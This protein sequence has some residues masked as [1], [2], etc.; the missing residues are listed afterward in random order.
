M[1]I[2]SR[3]SLLPCFSFSFDVFALG[4]EE[5]F[6]GTKTKNVALRVQMFGA[7][8]AGWFLSLRVVGQ[9]QPRISARLVGHLLKKHKP[10]KDSSSSVCR[11][12]T[13]P[14]VPWQ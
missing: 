8:P 10:G 9:V 12:G 6:E 1:S 4:L 7:V 2:C 11:G 14:S 13:H 3:L 5:P